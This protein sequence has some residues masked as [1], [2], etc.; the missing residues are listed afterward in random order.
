MAVRTRRCPACKGTNPPRKRKCVTCGRALPKRRRPAH[1]KALAL[2]YEHYVE[3]QGGEFC[4]MCVHLPESQRV[5]ANRKLDRD[6]SHRDGTPRGLLCSRH[7]R[8]LKS[9]YTPELLKAA[10]EYL[11]TA[12]NRRK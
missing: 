5:K 3:L 4:G 12:A 10:A 2:P 6:H 9:W 11:E 8:M 7:N 1:T